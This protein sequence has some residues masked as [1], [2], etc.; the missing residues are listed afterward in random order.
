MIEAPYRVARESLLVDK[1]ALVT[2]ASGSIGRACAEALARQGA[3][4]A[5]GFFRNESR[6]LETRALLRDRGYAVGIDVRNDASVSRAFEQVE[7]ELGPVQIMV[8][9]AGISRDMLLSRMSEEEWTDVI[10][11]D[12]SG[13]FR[14]TKRSLPT[15]LRQGWGRVITVG[16]VAAQVGTPLQSNYSAA[17]A[18]VVG[19]SR[20]LA[21]EVARHGITVNVVAPG[22]IESPMSGRLSEAMKRK[23]ID[24]IWMKRLGDPGDV[25]EAVVFCA[26]APYMTGQVISVDG[27]LS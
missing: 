20:S 15:M 17:K 27:G 4:V 26:S 11:T 8:N 6:A 16:S 9:N 12:L 13:V 3:R 19:F 25:A 2:G 14:C 7:A 18:G 5:L 23:V 1:V 21:R 22:L 10:D 24:H